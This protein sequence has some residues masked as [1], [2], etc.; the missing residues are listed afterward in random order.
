[1]ANIVIAKTVI[2]GVPN[3][4]P[5]NCEIWMQGPELYATR[6][7]DVTMDFKLVQNL[8]LDQWYDFYAKAPSN[9]TGDDGATILTINIPDPN[10][11]GPQPNNPDPYHIWVAATGEPIVRNSI[12]FAGLGANAVPAGQIQYMG[13]LRLTSPTNTAQPPNTNPVAPSGGGGGCLGFLPFP[14]PDV[15]FMTPQLWLIV[16]GGVGLMVLAMVLGGGGGDD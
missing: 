8:A 10:Y 4:P 2:E 13:S 3:P 11:P 7:V 1:M 14:C 16:G 5:N 12:G 9:A 6:I 15:S